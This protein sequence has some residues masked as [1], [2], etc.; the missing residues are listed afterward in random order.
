MVHMFNNIIILIRR[1]CLLGSQ[2]IPI[3]FLIFLSKSSVQATYKHL[4]VGCNI[5]D[6]SGKIIRS[7]NGNLC[8]FQDD[9][10]RIQSI[11]GEDANI[12][13]IR[14]YSLSNHVLWS[15]KDHPHHELQISNDKRK[16]FYLSSEFGILGNKRVRF[17]TLNLL[18]LK[19]GRLIGKWSFKTNF[20]NYKMILEHH[21]RPFRLFKYGKKLPYTDDELGHF[22]SLKEIPANKLYPKLKFLKPGNFIL[23]ANCL[24]LFIIF[25]HNLK[26]IE[27]VIDYNHQLDCNT[28]DA[29]V[30]PNGHFLHFNN[31]EAG[32]S[33]LPAKSSLVEIDPVS[34]LVYWKWPDVKNPYVFSNY[35]MGSV[36]RIENG[37][38]LFTDRGVPTSD[39]NKRIKSP[40]VNIINSF[41]EIIFTWKINFDTGQGVYRAKILNLDKFLENSL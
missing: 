36:Q 40:E 29:Q 41:G 26:K 7:Y 14:Y 38:T 23:G 15:H 30:L 25:N 37:Y 28:H 12:G 13:E 18:N 2:F 5:F 8:I 3:V 31:F 22:N 32:S 34:N 17:D 27:K 33:N 21:N 9:G 24:G 10:S 19:D 16:I 6:F 20:N 11:E 4:Q 35:G 39:S 1:I